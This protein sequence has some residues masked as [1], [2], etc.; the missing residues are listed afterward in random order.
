M[1]G[2]RPDV[3]PDPPNRQAAPRISTLLFF[4]VSGLRVTS[5]F[6]VSW[7]DAGYFV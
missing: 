6:R 7:R 3:L 1:T 5:I 2:Q 4:V